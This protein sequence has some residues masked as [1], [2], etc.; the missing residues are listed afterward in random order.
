MIDCLL[1]YQ[2]IIMIKEDLNIFL[3]LPL[4]CP[5]IYPEAKKTLIDF[6]CLILKRL[7]MNAEPFD[8]FENFQVLDKIEFNFKLIELHNTP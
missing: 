1:C 4:S 6:P 3:T 2:I 5:R 8:G 7:A